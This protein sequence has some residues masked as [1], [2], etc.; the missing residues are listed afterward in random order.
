MSVFTTA[1]YIYHS[2]LWFQD[3]SRSRVS[4]SNVVQAAADG[5]RRQEGPRRLRHLALLG[6]REFRDPVPRL[7]N[8][9]L[10]TRVARWFVFEPKIP[11]WVNFGGP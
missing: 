8:L 11:I 10:H 7:P 5:A 2:C 1:V 4:A 9:Q 3:D 6:T